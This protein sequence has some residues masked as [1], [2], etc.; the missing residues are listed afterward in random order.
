MKRKLTSV[1]IIMFIVVYISMPEKVYASPSTVIKIEAGEDHSLALAEDGTVWTWGG[2]FDKALGYDTISGYTT[3][4]AKVNELSGIVDIAAGILHSAVLKNNGTVWTWGENANGQLGDGTT[5]SRYT[6]VMVQGL[7]GIVDISCGGKTTLAVKNDGT[8]WAW[9]DNSYGQ[10][11]DGIDAIVKTP[12]QVRDISNLAAIA[13]G[14]DHVLALTR[15][16]KVYAW[17]QNDFGQI[18]DGT[19]F[20][21]STPTYIMSG[22][23]SIEAGM[24]DS[25]A[26][27]SDGSAWAWGYNASGQLGDG[28]YTHKKYPNKMIGILD[29]KA[30]S[31]KW[32][33]TIVL[34]TDGTVWVCGSSMYG[35]LGDGVTWSSTNKEPLLIPLSGISGARDVSGGSS[36]TIVLLQDGSVWG[37]GLD[38]Y[39]QIGD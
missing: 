28:T 19:I 36:Y 39:G 20:N 1:F 24:M 10:V 38:N 16:G 3:Y 25:Y 15:D 34:K 37:C 18:G 6:P 27:K 21:T 30:I 14:G 9:G 22:A 32:S 26:I 35:Q 7:S 23:S 8:L 17:G 31:G 29:V 11:G 4:P 33:H 5:T 13:G 12:V 2:N